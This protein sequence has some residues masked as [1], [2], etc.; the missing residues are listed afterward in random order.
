MTRGNI[1]NMTAAAVALLALSSL[2]QWQLS[3]AGVRLGYM[4]DVNGRP[5]QSAVAH[6]AGEFRIVAAN[7][8]WLKIVDHYHHQYL[9]Q[10]GSFATNTALIP[11]LRM[12]TWLDPHFTEA[13]DV[14]GLIMAQTKQYATADRFL[15]EGIANNPNNWL[16]N[17]D[18]AM[19]HAWFQKDYAAALPYAEHARDLADDP[20][21]KHRLSLF[22]NTL[23]RDIAA[24]AQAG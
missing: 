15:K 8:I 19:N 22:C 6:A 24:P 21:D 7:I 4:G 10:G 23:H 14:G 3:G 12:I 1:R 2:F 16:L 17:Y 13:Y 5:S 18:V 20:F 11:Y 9:A